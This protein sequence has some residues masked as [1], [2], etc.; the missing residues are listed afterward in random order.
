MRRAHVLSALMLCGLPTSLSVSAQGA[1]ATPQYR[2]TRSVPLGA[3]D[4]WDYLTFDPS[5]HRVYVA[6]G[7]RLSVFDG[8]DGTRI[9]EVTG[10]AGGTHGIVIL[11]A[12]G[13]GFTDDGRAG[14]AGSFD[15]A[16]LKAGKRIKAQDDADGMVYDAVSGH[17]FVVNGDSQTL[18]VIDPKTESAIATVA[19]GGKLEFAVAGDN[20][21]LYV[22][23]AG[24]NEIVRVDTRSNRADAHWPMAG[25]TSP[26]GLAIDRQ[27]HRLFAS[28]ANGVLAVVDAE[29]G[30]LLATLPIGAGTDAAAF[31]PVR[32]LVFSSNG[33]DGTLSIILEKDTHTYVNLGSIR[34]ATLA[35]TMTIDPQSGRLYL[36]AAQIDAAGAAAG[37]PAAEGA[38]RPAIVPGSAQLLFLDPA[39]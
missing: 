13:R 25:C 4:R 17:V 12:L 8:R 5:A 24:R 6:H 14:E 27:T 16:T 3:P 20:G 39:P 32:H 11:P 36:V 18:T 7:D 21:K 35:R 38:R 33:R 19:A 2:L 26:H 15:L 1:A 30:A 10:F 31:D 29:S 23:G 9:G 37:T 34:T 28:C 22:N